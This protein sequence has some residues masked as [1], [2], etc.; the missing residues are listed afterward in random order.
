MLMLNKEFDVIE[1]H[2]KLPSKYATL[3]IILLK[4]TCDR[5]L[6]KN[7]QIQRNHKLDIDYLNPNILTIF[8]PQISHI[9]K[10]GL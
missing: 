9:S 10:A 3:E 4:F 2:M 8:F 5:Q 1:R 6:E 7:W